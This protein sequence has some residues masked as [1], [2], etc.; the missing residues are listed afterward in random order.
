MNPRQMS[1]HVQEKMAE[2]VIILQKIIGVNIHLIP[3]VQKVRAA[4]HH[5]L[6]LTNVM[7]G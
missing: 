6:F 3:A 1:S 2:K 7:S 5:T 4:V